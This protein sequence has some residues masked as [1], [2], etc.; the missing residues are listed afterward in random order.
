MIPYTNKEC[1]QSLLDDYIELERK[2]EDLK[3]EYED[4]KKENRSN[5]A[6]IEFLSNENDELYQKTKKLEIALN[7]KGEVKHE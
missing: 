2:Y 6:I 7:R 1:Y 3:E 5:E 4:L